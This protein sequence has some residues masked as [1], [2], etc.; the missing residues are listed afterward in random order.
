MTP[1]VLPRL[2]FHD[3]NGRPLVGGK[4][5]TYLAGTTTPAV[6]YQDAAGAINNTNPV[7]L[8]ARGEANFFLN[9]ALNYKFVVRDSHDALIWTQE[10]IYGA[11][12]YG[13]QSGEADQAGV[14]ATQAAISAGESAD[15]AVDSANSAQQSQNAYAYFQSYIDQVVMNVTF[16]LDL[17]FTSDPFVYN[18][19][20]LGTT[21]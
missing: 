13:A 9:P 17:G 11:G 20:D 18:H 15:S 5:Y 21:S 14:Y 12:R 3:L 10:P 7:I 4:V 16:P 6:T 8:D 19:F 1:T 2:Y